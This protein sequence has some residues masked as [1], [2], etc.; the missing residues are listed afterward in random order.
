M[1]MATEGGIIWRKRN[2]D[3]ASLLEADPCLLKNGDWIPRMLKNVSQQNKIEFIRRGIDVQDVPRHK[4]K[5]G[6]W[7][8]GTLP[9]AG[10]IHVKPYPA[11]DACY[12]AQA[13]Q[14]AALV[15]PEVAHGQAGERQMRIKPRNEDISS[16]RVLVIKIG[17][18]VRE[19]FSPEEILERSH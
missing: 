7:F 4:E 3:A 8:E 16:D 10:L 1:L 15:T 17:E 6:I 18:P 13:L 14:H 2:E 9:N 5:L 12:L 19:K 11:A